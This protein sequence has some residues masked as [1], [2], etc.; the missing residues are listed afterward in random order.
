MAA[1]D[2]QVGIGVDLSELTNGLK[3]VSS[4]LE[5]FSKN[6]A[7]DAKQVGDS[8][9]NN[10]GGI[11]K[12]FISLELAS[13]G[14][15]AI[16]NVFLL[17]ERFNALKMP[18][19]NVTEATGDY[20]VALS[21]IT[22]LADQTGQDLFVLGDSYKGL[23]ASAKQA[24][25]ATTEIHNIFGAIVRSGSALKLSNEQ[26]ALS[27]KAVEQ[28]MNKG[29][30]SSEELKG[31]LGEQLPGA[32]AI[33]A[34]AAKDAG[35][36]VSGSTQELGKL[37]D[38]G[39]VASAEV[40]PFFAKRMEEAF[41]K[42]AD[43]NIN[44]ISGSA[45]RLNNELAQLVSALDES[46]VTSFWAS[47]Q[48]GIADV[49]KDLTFMVKSGSF[50]DFLSYMTGQGGTTTGMRLAQESTDAS[51]ASKN[52]KDQAKIYRELNLQ[53]QENVK[54]S[55]DLIKAGI[56][57][58]TEALSKLADQVK[59]Y[60]GLMSGTGSGGGGKTPPL[61]SKGEIKAVQDYSFEMSLLAI[62]I[63]A[64][65]ERLNRF[66]ESV[67]LADMRKLKFT[68]QAM[69]FTMSRSE[70]MAKGD[71]DLINKLFG[72]D[73]E[74]STQRLKDRLESIKSGIKPSI[75][76]FTTDL[77]KWI[78][79]NFEVLKS[80][81]SEVVGGLAD[82]FATGLG[83][84]FNQ[85]VKFDPKRMIGQ[86][87]ESVGAMLIGIATPLVAALALGNAATL[88]GMSV[89]WGAA[90]GMLGAGIAMKGG[91]MAMSSSSEN[92]GSYTTG[93]R[94]ISPYNQNG[95]GSMQ[96]VEVRFANG[97]LSGYIN[98]R[99]KKYNG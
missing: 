22:K 73:L 85:D 47:I 2:L 95:Y 63:K 69:S 75:T 49:M 88:G 12:G 44:T 40:L 20:G 53:L 37:L 3:K 1:S 31:Q 28:M 59:R 98:N 35:L 71:K 58:N 34:K 86:V 80:I 43:A 8:W 64:G 66:Y 55:R 9:T 51:F 62:E 18:L 26:V 78:S 48:N 10:L 23:Y 4:Q 82:I 11:V 7:N 15:S 67:K 36:S 32:Y 6:T 87:L 54:N 21:F 29:T 56:T 92:A 93:A 25:I 60:K 61:V 50:R 91:G 77:G 83:N 65:T 27:L 89:Q 84:M 94:S 41:G 17:E 30:I 46:K 70:D 19:R 74:A 39:K 96:T 52:P 14:L 38:E 90:L 72:S 16:K 79:K 24:G 57:P 45:N 33:M 76:A 81:T 42:N 99:N 5:S 13:R 68:P 97:A